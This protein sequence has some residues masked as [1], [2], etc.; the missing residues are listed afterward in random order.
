MNLTDKLKSIEGFVSYKPANG[1]QVSAAQRALNLS[2]SAEYTEYVKAYGVA[3]MLGHELTGVCDIP[4]LNVVNVTLEA[5]EYNPLVPHEWYVVE[6]AHIDGI[7][8]W[9]SQTGEIYQSQPGMQPEKIA[10]SLAE[11]LDLG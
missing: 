10:D 8:I 5:R 1:E 9:Q 3:S 2:F 7:M 11:Y 4:R 6:E